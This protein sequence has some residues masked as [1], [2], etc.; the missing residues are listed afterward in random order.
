MCLHISSV[1]EMRRTGI[2][3]RIRKNAWPEFSE[4]TFYEPSTGATIGTVV[5]FHYLLLMG[6]LLSICLLALERLWCRAR[7][8]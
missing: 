6:L 8:Q 7:G 1:Q 3:N 5:I 4:D 2:L